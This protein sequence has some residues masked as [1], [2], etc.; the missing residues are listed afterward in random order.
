MGSHL[1]N[2]LTI[3]AESWSATQRFAITEESWFS[4]S[5]ALV[6]SLPTGHKTMHREHTTDTFPSRRRNPN[7]LVPPL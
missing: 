5:A 6:R 4:K 1:P 7:F 3:A 2:A